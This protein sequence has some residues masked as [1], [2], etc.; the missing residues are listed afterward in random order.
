MFDSTSGTNVRFNNTKK[1][2]GEERAGDIQ[3][4]IEY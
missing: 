3:S 1:K 2:L 4:V